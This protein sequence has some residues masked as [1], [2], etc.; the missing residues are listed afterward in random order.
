MAVWLVRAGRQGEN[1]QAAL[2]NSIVTI[3]WHAI[4]G[5]VSSLQGVLQG[6]G[7]GQGLLVSWG[8]FKPAVRSGDRE[9]QS[10]GP[11]CPWP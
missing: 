9:T 3:G 7:A 8:G 4:R 11:F 6:F 5:N 2:D 1:E 10:G